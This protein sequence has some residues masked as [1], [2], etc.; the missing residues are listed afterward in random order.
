VAPGKGKTIALTFDDGP[1]TDDASIL[2]ILASNHVRAT[3]FVTGAHSAAMPDQVAALAAAGHL[4]ENHSFGHDYP[5]AVPG[6]WTVPYLQD[7]ILRTN[8]V[9]TALTGRPVC[10]FRPPGGYHDNV[11]DAS[12]A[13]GLTAVLWSLDSRD[14]KQ[15]DHVTPAATAAI[16]AAATQVGSQTHPILLMHSA[17]ASHEPEP[18]VS[19][20][21]GNT[22]AALPRIITWYQAHGYRFVDLF[23]QS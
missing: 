21:R 19:A 16:V 12:R 2:A 23:G 15:P 20:F 1:G 3:F 9:V 5:P 14:W 7:Q 10:F 13:Q 17:K 6:G 18:V 11:L 4:V 8:A 22:L